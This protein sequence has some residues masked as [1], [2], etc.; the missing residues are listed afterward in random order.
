MHTM[1]QV[2]STLADPYQRGTD[3]HNPPAYC[4]DAV[5]LLAHIL[6]PASPSAWGDN[7]SDVVRSR[8]QELREEMTAAMARRHEAPAAPPL[9]AYRR[10][11]RGRTVAQTTG[12][13][14][15]SDYLAQRDNCF[16]DRRRTSTRL[17]ALNI[18]LENA[19]NGSRVDGKHMR[20]SYE[21]A[22]PLALRAEEEGRPCR[23]WL[24]MPKNI[25]KRPRQWD[26]N[27]KQ[28]SNWYGP[29]CAL[30]LV[31]LKDWTDPIAAGAWQVISSNVVANALRI[32]LSMSV[33]GS[34]DTTAGGPEF[35]PLTEAQLPD[36]GDCH[37]ITQADAQGKSNRQGSYLA[38]PD[39]HPENLKSIARG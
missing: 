37:I 36:L 11:R 15:V 38:L 8:M 16:R 33:A 19:I 34:K 4:I 35:L 39:D 27:T 25:D 22:W 31:C 18:V 14:D 3:R 6:D 30:F 2:L 5:D 12:S 23:V 26:I 7:N 9:D 10:K 17:P 28:P 32:L 1:Q 24:A 29:E 20:V 13:L 21:I